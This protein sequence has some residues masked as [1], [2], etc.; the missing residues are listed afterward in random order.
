MR[1]LYLPLALALCGLAHHAAAQVAPDSTAPAAAATPPPAAPKPRKF[2]DKFAGSDK[3]SFIPVPVLFS[4]QETGLAGGLSI[5]PVWRFGTDTTTRKSNARFVGWISQKGQTSLQVTH[6]IFTPGEKMYLLGEISYYD[7]NF[8]YYG[9]GNNTRKADESEVDYKLFIFNQRVMPRIAPN[10]FAGLQYRFTGLRGVAFDKPGEEGGTNKFQQDLNE[11]I[12]SQREATGGNTSGFGPAVLYDGRD[13]VL[14]TYRGQYLHV[15]GL[16]TGKY[17]GSDY[18]FS[19]YQ[20]DARHFQPLFGSNNT[21][22]AVQYL[23]QFH[24]GG[25]VPFREL[26]AFG[27][28][29]GGSIYNY[30][31]LMRGIYEGRFRDRQMMTFQAEIRRKLFWRF[32]GVVFGAVGEVASQFNDFSLGGTKVAAGFGGRFRFNRRDRLNLRLDYGVGSGGNSGI[33]FAVGEAF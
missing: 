28:D 6:N 26:S 17:A 21:I 29:L 16:F 33:Y 24:S 12:L 9:V 30:S 23:G 19:R 14:S 1:F 10:L 25:R 22:L 4:Q 13:N 7:V 5:L 31:T 11:G 15:H 2:A 3:P 27:A 20:I 32:D 8:F 18:T